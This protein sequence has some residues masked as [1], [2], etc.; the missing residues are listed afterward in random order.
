MGRLILRS[1]HRLL[2]G[3]SRSP[4]AV[5]RLLDGK[6]IAIAI[7]SPPYASQRKYDESS[8]FVPIPPDQYVDW[9]EPIQ[10]NVRQHLAP[11]GSFFVNIKEH[12]EDGQRHLYVKDLTL[13]HVRRWGWMFVDEL[14]W[15][16]PGLPGGWPNRFKNDFEPVFH[17]A[18]QQDIKF[19]PLAVGHESDHIRV[20]DGGSSFSPH[21]NI[22][23]EGEFRSGIARPGNVIEVAG[24]DGS[25][26]VAFPI[27]L[28]A[29]F[30]KAF[31]DADDLIYEPFCGSGTTLIAAE[32]LGRQCAAMEIS[33]SYCDISVAR[34]E[35]FTGQ[36]AVRWES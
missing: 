22:T 15:K 29:F 8:G 35:R 4:E 10:E 18:S 19:R 1:K 28:P 34:W 27:G 13:A 25:H 26:P 6:R 23:V 31:S 14:I 9:W 16:K 32:Q 11:D 5:D 12:C 33:P 21:G 3:D 20:Y 7:T 30:I 24:A 17:F 36:K 2:C